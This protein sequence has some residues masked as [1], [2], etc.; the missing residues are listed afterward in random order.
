MVDVPLS[1]FCK[2]GI[3]SVHTEHQERTRVTSGMRPRVKDI[4]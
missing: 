4:L 1:L 3:L 2:R